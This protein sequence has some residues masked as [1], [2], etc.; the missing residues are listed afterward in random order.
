M[1]RTGNIMRKLGR[2]WG[3]KL[4]NTEE[5]ILKVISE[6]KFCEPLRAN[7]LFRFFTVLVTICADPINSWFSKKRCIY[8]K[9]VIVSITIIVMIT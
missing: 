7:L 2:R 9:L 1:M 5:K 8:Q 4:G 6:N 3:E